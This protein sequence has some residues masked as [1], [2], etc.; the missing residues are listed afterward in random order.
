MNVQASFGLAD[1]AVLPLGVRSLSL[2]VRSEIEKLVLGHKFPVGERLSEA[3]FATRF[4]VSRGPVREAFRALVEAG[5]LEFIPNRGV[6]VR[7]I[8]LEQAIAD[9]EVRAGLFGLA[10]RLAAQRIRDD[11][12]AALRKLVKGMDTRIGAGDGAGYYKLNLELHATILAATRNQRLVAT[13]ENLIK[14]LH[15]FRAKNW[16]SPSALRVSNAEHVAMIAALGARDEG[17]AFESHFGHV[18][19]AKGRAIET[20]AR[21]AASDESQSAKRGI[22]TPRANRERK[23]T[24]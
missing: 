10:G 14:N 1:D 15:M 7:Q 2:V 18:M 6:F 13:Y 12:I 4:G 9:Y 16:D 22:R 8:S 24:P 19:N 20:A 23:P 11:E 5:L 3:Y 21:Q 17:A